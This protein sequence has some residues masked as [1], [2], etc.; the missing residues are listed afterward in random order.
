MNVVTPPH[1][2]LRTVSEEIPNNLLSK[3]RKLIQGMQQTL[4]RNPGAV[5][6][7]A[8]QVGIT[9]RVIVWALPGKAVSYA[10]NP[11]FIPDQHTPIRKGAEGCL[12]LPGEQGRVERFHAGTLRYFD[13]NG[14][15]YAERAEGLLPRIWQHEIDHLNGILFT[16][17]P[18]TSTQ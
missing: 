4:R 1:P 15:Y 10:I 11:L 14:D 8:N 18:E 3:Q 2:A 17:Y 6:L 12:S 7:A 9:K 16:D 5:G 13:T